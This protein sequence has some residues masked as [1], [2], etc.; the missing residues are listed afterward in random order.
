MIGGGDWAKDRL[1]PDILS[2][3]SRGEPVLVRSPHAIRPWQHVLEPLRGYLVLA[4]KLHAEGVAFAEAWNFGPYPD[5]ARPVAW[6]AGELARRWGDGASWQIS[7]GEH[8]HEA[9]YLKLDIAKATHRLDWHPALRLGEAL[10]LIVDWARTRQRG[11][12]MRELTLQQI[13]HYQARALA[14]RP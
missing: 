12:D 9:N 1:I 13:A 5:D 2:A 8:P 10:D 7:E 11:G 3:F 14:A 6:I 4:E